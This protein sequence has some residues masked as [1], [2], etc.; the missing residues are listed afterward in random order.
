MQK[1]MM[2][3]GENTSLYEDPEFVVGANKNLLK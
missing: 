1:T 3:K 2:Y